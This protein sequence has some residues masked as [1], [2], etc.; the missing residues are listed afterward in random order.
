MK[1]NTSVLFERWSGIEKGAVGGVAVLLVFSLC[2]MLAPE[3]KD[4]PELKRDLHRVQAAGGS[5][6]S[7]KVVEGLRKATPPASMAA[8]HPQNDGAT[9]RLAWA[10][11]GL[12]AALASEDDARKE[13]EKYKDCLDS[14]ALE[15]YR[16]IQPV[17]ARNASLIGAKFESLRAEAD[18]ITRQGDRV[19]KRD[20]TLM[21]PRLVTK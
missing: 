7:L 8:P 4:A 12:K 14:P 2:T 19:V 20:P 11:S 18:S 13:L 17:C 15:K 1:R 3:G 10:F 16:S 21:A 5:A 6:P 9:Q